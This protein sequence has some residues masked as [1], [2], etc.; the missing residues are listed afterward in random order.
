MDDLTG[1]D[2][3]PQLPQESR[4]GHRRHS[5]AS[6]SRTG[7]DRSR[8]HQFLRRYSAA[9]LR[10]LRTQIQAIW[11]GAKIYHDIGQ[12]SAWAPGGDSL[13][14]V[15]MHRQQVRRPVGRGGLCRSLRLPV[16]GE[17]AIQEAR[18][19]STSERE[20]NFVINSM[21]AVPVWLDQAHGG[22]VLQSRISDQGADSRL[23]LLRAR[24]P[25]RRQPDLLV[26]LEARDLQRH[27]L[28]TSRGLDVDNCRRLPVDTDAR[29]CYTVVHHMGKLRARRQR[30][31]PIVSSSPAAPVIWLRPRPGT[32]RPGP[33]ESE[34]LTRSI[35]GQGS[36]LFA[37]GRPSFDFV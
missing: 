15:L 28:G 9:Q 8:H 3:R 19:L 33:L 18:G 30:R 36:L 26:C 32:P 34:S 7:R 16:R 22:L 11:P 6:T 24:R 37:W 4:V 12:P 5:T 10:Q 17:R 27:P 14:R 21:H 23:E 1:I 2:R 31:R 35:H 25:A 13:Q 29:V 20:T